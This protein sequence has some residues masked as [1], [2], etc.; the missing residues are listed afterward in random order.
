M[1]SVDNVQSSPNRSSS[2]MGDTETRKPEITTEE[3]L[4]E[5]KR[6]IKLLSDSGC[7]V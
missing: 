3:A 1:E 4:E 5:Q 7:T 6:V 2:I